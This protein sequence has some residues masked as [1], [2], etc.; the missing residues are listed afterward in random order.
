MLQIGNHRNRTGCL[1]K[2]NEDRSKKNGPPD[3]EIP[4]AAPR[5]RK[6]KGKQHGK[7]HGKLHGKLHGKRRRRRGQRREL[8]IGNWKEGIGKGQ[9]QRGRTG[10]PIHRMAPSLILQQSPSPDVQNYGVRY[11]VSSTTP[12]RK[13]HRQPGLPGQS[14]MRGSPDQP[15][16]E[17]VSYALAV[18]RRSMFGRSV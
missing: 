6:R 9:C 13:S 1:Q 15:A 3:V 10:P 17:K 14:P 16:C 4:R 11:G 12:Y 5:G 18:C 2:G 7:Q 8:G